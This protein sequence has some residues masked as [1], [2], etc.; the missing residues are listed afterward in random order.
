MVAWRPLLL[1]HS[2]ACFGAHRSHSYTI[3][4][5]ELQVHVAG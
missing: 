3:I 5:M 2:G 4:M 1:R